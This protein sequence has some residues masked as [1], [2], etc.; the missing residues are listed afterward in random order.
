MQKFAEETGGKALA[1]GWQHNA[2]EQGKLVSPG[3]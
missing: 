3:M 1:G 2:R